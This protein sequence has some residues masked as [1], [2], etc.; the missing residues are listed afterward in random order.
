M[1]KK[2]STKKSTTKSIQSGIK[3]VQKGIDSYKSSLSSG[4]EKTAG[5]VYKTVKTPGYDSGIDG[6]LDKGI[7]YYG[8]QAQDFDEGDIRSRQL[9]LF[10]KEIDA[11]NAIYA[12]QLASAAIEG[13]G[14]LGSTR[15]A[16]A[17]GGLLGSDFGEANKESTLGLNRSIETGIQN[18]KQ[19]KIAEILGKANASASAEI[20]AKRTAQKEGLDQYLQFLGT[21]NERKEQYKTDL[22]KTFLEQGIAPEE[23]DPKELNKIAKNYGLKSDDVLVTYKSAKKAADDAKAAADAEAKQK[24]SFNLSEGQDRYEYD[25]IT[26]EYNLI[27]SK[28]KT[29]APKEGGGAGVSGAEYKLGENPTVDAYTAQVRSGAIK[30]SQV[31]K[32]YKDKVAQ[33]LSGTEGG[34]TLAQKNTISARDLVDELITDPGRKAGTGKSAVFSKL[35]ATKARTFKKKAERLQALLSLEAIQQMRGLG[36]LSDMEGQR[37][38]NSVSIL[39]DPYIKEEDYLA[40]LTRLRGDLDTAAKRIDQGIGSESVDEAQAPGRVNTLSDAQ[41][42]SFDASSLSDAEYEEA[43][44]DG[45]TPQ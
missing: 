31:P 41:G 43:L 3:N 45:Y 27:A 21:K 14:R 26:G 6:A 36:A 12:D 25:P 42:N 24:N 30:L 35:P 15:A 1:A 39:S 34:Y 37:I 4:K 32:D 16:S 2:K 38:S 23:I 29:Y 28:A 44:A 13:R 7:K 8:K 19:N 10:Q 22:A 17:R 9:S 18:E 20:Q 11:T 33:A 40:E 5:Q